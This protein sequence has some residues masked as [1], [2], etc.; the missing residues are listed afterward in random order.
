MISFFLSFFAGVDRLASKDS[1]L[2]WDMGFVENYAQ[3]KG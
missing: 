2:S 1:A 3:K